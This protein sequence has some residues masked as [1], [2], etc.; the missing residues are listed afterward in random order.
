MLPIL[1]YGDPILR[2]PVEDVTDF[3]PL[4]DMADQMFNTMYQEGGIGLAAMMH[5]LRPI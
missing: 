3:K 5:L 4:S 2:K 1:K